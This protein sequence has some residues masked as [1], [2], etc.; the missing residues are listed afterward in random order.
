MSRCEVAVLIQAPRKL[1]MALE[2]LKRLGIHFAVC[3]PG[4]PLC[5][6][7]DV[8]LVSKDELPPSRDQRIVTI[9]DDTVMT[10]LDIMVRLRK[11]VEPSCIMVGIDPGMRFGLAF[12]IDGRVIAKDAA[13][14][15]MIAVDI[16]I[17]WL[18]WL[19]NRFSLITPIV[20]IGTGYRL[21][22]VLYTRSLLQRC[23]KLHIEFVNESHT[24]R[25]NSTLS[26]ESAAV[27]IAARCGHAVTSSDLVLD[28][29]REYIHHVKRI[30]T[31]HNSS[32]I[33]TDE[34][35][36]IIR[37]DIVLEDLL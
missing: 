6:V 24:T 16:T 1:Y 23:P 5:T 28:S 19:N 30:F 29:K 33:S 15:P 22:S 37:G 31:R 25:S 12:V 36:A 32:S 2:L 8:V 20:R 10:E 35:E 11:V 26:D 13:S 34:A 18:S 21:Y 4:D 3:A 27:V 17:R 9:D 7:A 14:S